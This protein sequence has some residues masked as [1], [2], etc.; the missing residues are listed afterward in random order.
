MEDVGVL[1]EDVAVLKE[2]V[3]TLKI[4]TKSIQDDIG[5]RKGAHA[6]DVVK[7][8]VLAFGVQSAARSTIR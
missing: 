1:K 4:R 3:D 6:R 5:T 7:A 8:I 2:D